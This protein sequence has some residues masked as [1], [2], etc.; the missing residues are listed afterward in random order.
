MLL[1][2]CQHNKTISHPAKILSGDSGY[3]SKQVLLPYM[4]S[5]KV[6]DTT[7]SSDLWSM[8]PD[9]AIMGKYYRNGD[10]YIICAVIANSPFE[11]LLLMKV[12]AEEHVENYAPYIHSNY[13]NCWN[14]FGFGKIDGYFYV[15]TC[16]TGTAYTG[17]Y[18]N[19][20]KDI[21]PQDSS[22][23]I[24][25]FNWQGLMSEDINY[26]QANAIYNISNDSIYLNY[27]ITEG[28]RDDSLVITREKILDTFQVVYFMKAGQWTTNDTAKMMG[29]A[30]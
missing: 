28:H 3:L 7:G 19:F 23:S 5:E 2:A 17:S 22:K 16:G 15:N 18:M 27:T 6:L 10:N 8:H 14:E 26:Q 24:T 21:V 13:C 11:S 4:L 20:F 12:N 9:S 30:L 1:A 29:Y 25:V